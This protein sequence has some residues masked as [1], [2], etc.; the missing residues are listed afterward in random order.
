MQRHDLVYLQ[1]H[2]SYD[3]MNVSLPSS[4]TLAVDKMIQLQQPL[5]VCRQDIDSITKV[6]TSYIEDGRKYRLAI[7][8]PKLPQ[9]ITAPLEL[10]A[11]IPQ[12]P[13]AIQQPTAHFIERC[14]RLE[15]TVH[16]YGSFANQY[17]T[18]LSFVKPTSDLDLLIVANSDH[19]APILLELATFNRLASEVAGLKIDGEVR[20][21]GGNDI[22]FSELTCAIMFDIPTVLVKTLDNI[23][24]QNIDVLLG[25]NTD[26]YEHFIRSNAPAATVSAGHLAAH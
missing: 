5:T 7:T 1:P 3:F 2:E 25:W 16:A 4:V 24:L 26:D 14:T 23:Q 12:L 20:L 11:L 10:A 19:I 9:V 13:K 15:C 18:G 21:H 17:F 22:S 8:L 6:A